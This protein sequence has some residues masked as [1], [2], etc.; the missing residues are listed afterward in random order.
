[1]TGAT[2]GK[3]GVK[4]KVTTRGKERNYA[5]EPSYCTRKKKK[6]RFKGIGMERTIA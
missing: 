6:R 5:E 1:M 3:K 4:Q 2:R